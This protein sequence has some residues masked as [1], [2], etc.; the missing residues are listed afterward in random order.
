MGLTARRLRKRG[1]QETGPAGELNPKTRQRTSRRCRDVVE[2][3]SSEAS[4][5]QA[6]PP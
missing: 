2:P 1:Q 5:T 4:S 6:L 3:T